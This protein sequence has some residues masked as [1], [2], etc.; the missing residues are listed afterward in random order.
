M[1]FTF[2]AW[3]STSRMLLSSSM[4]ASSSSPFSTR[5][6]SSGTAACSSSSRQS[7]GDTKVLGWWLPAPGAPG[8]LGRNQQDGRDQHNV[9]AGLQLP[10]TEPSPSPSMEWVLEQY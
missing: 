1:G 9:C 4:Q 6:C 10:C 8:T 5:S 7:V 3:Y 2:W